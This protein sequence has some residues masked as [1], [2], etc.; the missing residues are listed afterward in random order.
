MSEQ[1]DDFVAELSARDL[2]RMTGLSERAIT[3]RC[4]AGA[5][6]GA[7]MQHG[8]WLIPVPI[9][10]DLT[11]ALAPLYHSGDSGLPLRADALQILQT[12]A[13][14][15]EVHEALEPHR[16]TER[17]LE[18]RL[19]LAHRALR[20]A[21]EA[22]AAAAKRLAAAEGEV[23][24]LTAEVVRLEEALGQITTE[25]ARLGARGVGLGSLFRGAPRPR[26]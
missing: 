4:A 25:V 15:Q 5:Y 22:A 20:A 23:A 13:T 21:G 10:L 3:K 6:P 7:R 9:P 2:A 26:E 8:R 24:Q 1:A 18:R 11:R 16:A 12:Y 19:D 17:D 14:R